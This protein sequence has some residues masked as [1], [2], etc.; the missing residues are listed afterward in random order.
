M[1]FVLWFWIL[2]VKSNTLTVTS[3]AF[4]ANGFIPK[5]HTCQGENI[6]PGI[7]IGNIPA[8]TKSLALIVED[9]DAPDGT[10]IHWIVWNIEPGASITENSVPGEEGTTSFGVRNY[11][12][13]C[14]PSGTHRYFFKVFAL[15]DLLKLKSGVDARSLQKAMDGHILGQGELIGKYQ[16]Q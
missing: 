15:D 12:G 6:N 14:P 10:F 2:C 5:K 16:K 4:E 9:P 11:S 3:P 8:A 7:S 13:P 1:L